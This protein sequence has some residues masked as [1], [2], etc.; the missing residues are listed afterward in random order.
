MAVFYFVTRRPILPEESVAI[1]KYLDGM[2]SCQLDVMNPVAL[3]H[4]FM[5]VSKTTKA[6]RSCAKHIPKCAM[7]TPAEC[8][9]SS[10]NEKLANKCLVR[11]EAAHQCYLAH[12]HT[13][14]ADPQLKLYNNRFDCYTP[15]EKSSIC[16]KKFEKVCNKKRLRATKV[17]RLSM[18]SVETLIEKD[19][20]IYI[21]FYVRDPRGVFVSRETNKHMPLKALCKQMEKDHQLYTELK[22]KYPM[23]LHMM[24]YEDLAIHQE[25]ALHDLFGFIDEPIP[26]TTRKYLASITNAASD[27]GTYGVKRSDS[28]KTANAWR[29][30]ITK[31]VY[32]ESRAEC[33]EIIDLL[34]YEL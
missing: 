29:Q 26:E 27:G 10:V 24:R 8:H 18:Q 6:L 33:A 22:L 1:A 12:N 4:H 25:E 19:P 9:T 31:D 17:H 13:H 21:V 2:M 20:E 28:A 32:A 5:T 16:V 7:N 34:G 15:V 3:T 14:C 30:K 23:S 11:L